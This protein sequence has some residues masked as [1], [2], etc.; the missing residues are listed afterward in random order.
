IQYKGDVNTCEVY[1]ETAGE[2]VPFGD[3]RNLPKYFSLSGVAPKMIS[4]RRSS[5][6]NIK[7]Y[8]YASKAAVSG[9][10]DVEKEAAE[11]SKAVK[12]I[13]NGKIVIVKGGKK[14]TV[15]GAQIK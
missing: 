14:Y 7:I 13:E 11:A 10:T 8:R 4:H 9:I 2:T 5:I 15:A 12:K 3:I 6:D 1:A